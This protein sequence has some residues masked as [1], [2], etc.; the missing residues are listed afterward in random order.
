MTILDANV[1]LGH[2]PFRKLAIQSPDDLHAE[3]ARAGIDRALV[4][5]LNA[6]LWKDVQSANM[7]LACLVGS[8]WATPSAVVDP[9]RPGAL[10]DLDEA[11]ESLAA[12][13]V[14]LFPGYHCYPLDAPGVTAFFERLHHSQRRLPV[15]ITVRLEDERMH[16]PVARVRPPEPSH[17]AALVERFPEAPI[18]LV[19]ITLGEAKQVR[20]AIP[21]DSRVYYE[22]SRMTDWEFLPT[23]LEHLPAEQL[24]FGTNLPLYVPECAVY[25]VAEPDL[26]ESIK[27]KVFYRNLAP[28]LDSERRPA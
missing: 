12:R 11:I 28:L 15:L 1:G 27:E 7:E 20:A 14:R 2:W 18:I 13:A 5:S 22:I 25:K 23:A 17:L 4:Y 21:T 6:V 10:R 3:L 19:G 24:V 26:P 16:H 9:T 8:A